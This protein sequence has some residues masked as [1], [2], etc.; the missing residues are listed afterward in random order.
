MGDVKKCGSDDVAPPNCERVTVTQKPDQL[1]FETTAGQ[2]RYTKLFACISQE[3]DGYTVEVTLFNERKPES[4]AWGEEIVDSF[5]TASEL[6]AAVAGQF[7]ITQT[8][9]KIEIRLRNHK[10]GTRH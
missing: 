3:E 8:S 7:S 10:Q 1:R 5:E 9:I 4:S 6:V 2:P